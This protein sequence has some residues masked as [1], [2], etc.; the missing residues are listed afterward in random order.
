MTGFDRIFDTAGLSDRELRHAQLREI[1]ALLRLP[2]DATH[3]SVV[4]ALLDIGKTDWRI[5]LEAVPV[6]YQYILR[7]EH[8]LRMRAVSTRG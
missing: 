8:R 6:R 1:R 5:D 7:I 4:R 3:A 2:A